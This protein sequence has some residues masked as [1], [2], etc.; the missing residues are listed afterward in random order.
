MIISTKIPFK[1]IVEVTWKLNLY[2]IVY[3]CFSYLV[4]VNYL[5]DHFTMSGAVPGIMGTAIAFFIGFNN[6]QA[7][8]R[9]KEA[10][11]AWGAL[12]TD[13]KS[14]TR[15]LLFQSQN[16]SDEIVLNKKI[17]IKRLIA[18]S[19][20]QNYR[21]RGHAKWEKVS[22]YLTDSEYN[23]AKEKTHVP[24]AILSLVAKDLYE[25]QQK[26]IIDEANYLG[27]NEILLNVARRIGITDRIKGTV[28]PTT[29]DFFTKLFIWLFLTALTMATEAE[30]GLWSILNSTMVG[31]VFI[32]THQVGQALLNPF[33]WIRTGVP[34]NQICTIIERS[35]LEMLEE[36]PLPEMEPVIDGQYIM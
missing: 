13:C 3:S 6:N 30:M 36:T 22:K 26:D 23:W 27:I 5:K 16:P 21:L 31:F 15:I 9:W 8:E 34:M 19:Y 35:L 12:V 10:R 33:E 24:N 1:R 32:I 4:Y 29:Y 11:Q 7:Y 18:L 20:A 2:T 25:L 17:L 28:F 14:F